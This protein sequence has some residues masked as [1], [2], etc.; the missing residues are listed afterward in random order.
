MGRLGYPILIN[1]SRVFALSEL[2]PYIQAYRQARKEAGYKGE[3][4]VGLRVPVYVAETA[5]RAYSEPKASTVQAMS[6]LGDVIAST[7]QGIGVTDD[8]LAQA[9]RIRKMDYDDW[10]RDKVV[11]GTPEAVADRFCQLQEELG[12]TEIIY[13]VN[14]GC[15]IP[16]DR[17]LNSMRLLTERVVPN[18]K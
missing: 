11:Y 4:E 13:E 5:E 12:L 10:L 1:P 16:H 3:G 2:G 15:Q 9:E 17:Q 7:A 8:R 14:F 6:R 18:F